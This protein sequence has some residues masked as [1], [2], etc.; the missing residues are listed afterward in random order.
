[1][2]LAKVVAAIGSAEGLVTFVKADE[3]ATQFVTD[4]HAAA[5]VAVLARNEADL[6]ALLV[7]EGWRK[8][9][10]G[11]VVAWTDDYSD[12]IGAMVRKKLGR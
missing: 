7:T 4:F 1:M 9:D 6:G 10:A 11:T 2:E 5:L 3:K 12:I 8:T